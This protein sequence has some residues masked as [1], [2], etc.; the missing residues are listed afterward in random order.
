MG[1]LPKWRKDPE[2]AEQNER[3]S[4]SEYLIREVGGEVL[5]SLPLIESVAEVRLREASHVA[6]RALWN[7]LYADT[8]ADRM[9]DA[10]SRSAFSGL[11]PE[12]GEL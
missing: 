2:L 6:R 7:G 1:D 9:R 12:C 4:R 11:E 5:P 3:A 10:K 8:R